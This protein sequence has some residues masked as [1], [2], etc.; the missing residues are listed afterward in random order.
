MKTTFSLLLASLFLVGCATHPGPI[1]VTYESA[2][3][4]PLASPGGKFG[5]LPHAVQNTIV[6][7]TGSAEISDIATINRLGE[8]SYEVYFHNEDNLP[9]LLVA[10]N[11]SVLNPDFSIAVS[12]IAEGAASATPPTVSKIQYAELPMALVTVINEKAA[13]APIE[14]IEKATWGDR[15][16]YVISF[17]DDLARPKLYITSDGVILKDAEK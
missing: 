14:S 4:R 13:N 10:S 17:K 16:L 15:T 3:L 11:G 9:P 1:E 6:A 5:A 12:A 7:E 8:I 2:Y